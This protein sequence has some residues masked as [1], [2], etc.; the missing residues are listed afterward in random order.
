VTLP[1]Q[2]AS[3]RPGNLDGARA[4]RPCQKKIARAVSKS[5]ER[6]AIVI[7]RVIINLFFFVIFCTSGN[8]PENIAKKKKKRNHFATTDTALPAFESRAEIAPEDQDSAES[9]VE[10][11]PTARGGK[12]LKKQL[13]WTK[14]MARSA[15]PSEDGGRKIGLKKT[16][17]SR[18]AD[19]KIFELSGPL[20]PPIRRCRGAH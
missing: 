15:L 14:R 10:F 9:R 8:L 2:R 11:A 13:S 20:R 18:V 12:P 19:I 16:A 3:T 5:P 7:F 17:D 1:S 6:R 4:E